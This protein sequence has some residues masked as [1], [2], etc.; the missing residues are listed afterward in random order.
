MS[1]QVASTVSVIAQAPSWD[2]RVQRVRQ[3]PEVYGLAQQTRSAPL[4]R[5]LA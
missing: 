3:I 2:V 1:A 4:K 5:V